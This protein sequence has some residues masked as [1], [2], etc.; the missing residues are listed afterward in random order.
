MSRSRAVL[1][2]LAARQ[3][4]RQSRDRPWAQPQ[5]SSSGIRNRPALPVSSTS[6]STGKSQ[7]VPCIRSGK[8]ALQTSSSPK[9]Q[10]RPFHRQAV[11]IA[12][13]PK[14]ET[15]SVLDRLQ[16]RRDRLAAAAR[17]TSDKASI[18][19]GTTKETWATIRQRHGT[20]RKVGA[21]HKKQGKLPTHQ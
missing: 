18:T 5:P 17:P 11:P 4:A 20:Q 8:A 1:D 10:S 19:P 14:S 2:L 13:S 21:S 15:R 12:V 9:V 3:A 7:P 6:T 16:A